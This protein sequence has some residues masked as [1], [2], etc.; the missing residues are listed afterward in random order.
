M[1]RRVQIASMV[2]RSTARVSSRGSAA[3]SQVPG[4]PG[5]LQRALWVHQDSQE[6]TAARL[7]FQVEGAAAA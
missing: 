6:E 7:R 5:A 1:F 4:R 3:R 2:A